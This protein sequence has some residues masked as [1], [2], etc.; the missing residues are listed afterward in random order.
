MSSGPDLDR[1]AERASREAF[2]AVVVDGADAELVT[3]VLA[4]AR[5]NE[6][7]DRRLVASDYEDLPE[8]VRVVPPGLIERVLAKPV[9][10]D[11]LARVVLG[12]DPSASAIYR[13]GLNEPADLRGDQIDERLRDLIERILELPTVVVR[14]IGPR[15]HVPRVQLVVPVTDPLHELR[16]ELPRLIGWPLK[17]AGSEMGATYR[18]HPVRRILGNLSE[19]QEVYV[20]GSEA[21]GYVAFFPWHDD[22]KVTIVIGFAESEPERVIALQRLAIARAREFPLP[23]RHRHSPEVFYD[24]V[25]DWVITQNYVGPDRRRKQTSFLNRYTFRGR[26]RALM[27]NEFAAAGTFVDLA[28]RW[29]WVSAAVFAVLFL[30]DTAMTSYYVG[31]GQVGE[32]NPLMRVALAKHPW[33]FWVLK[34]AMAVVIAFVVLR[35]HLWRPGRWLF[36]ACIGIYAFLDA[37]WVALYMMRAV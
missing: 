26:R 11:D 1:A 21:F 15:D 5:D 6:G 37:Y 22:Q 35:W 10:P 25:Y 30:F 27:P 3:A 2:D 24:P 23:T 20:L 34:T 17:A 13:W 12:D 32:L 36:A 4:A 33:V 8:L 29:A 14:P 18:G 16:R 31:G 28:P 7:I 19:R 9:G